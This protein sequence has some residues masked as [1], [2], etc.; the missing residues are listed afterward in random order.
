[1]ACGSA[2]PGGTAVLA[3]RR[4]QIEPSAR[5][6]PGRATAGEGTSVR[7][8]G[9]DST[10]GFRAVL[11]SR[12]RLSVPAWELELLTRPGQQSAAR[13][14]G[15]PRMHDGDRDAFWFGGQ[16]FAEDLAEHLVNDGV[17]PLLFEAI[18]VLLGLP[19]VDVP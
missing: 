5:T 9:V 2:A 1:M 6:M 4:M 3:S 16:T 17:D 13:R 14:L 12:Q 7:A 8:S 15:M 19:D 10:S 18:P 11:G